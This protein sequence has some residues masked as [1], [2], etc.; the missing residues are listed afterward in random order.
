MNTSNDFDTANSGLRG[1]H[2][3]C[4]CANVTCFVTRQDHESICLSITFASNLKTRLHW[5]RVL[6]YFLQFSVGSSYNN[7]RAV[8]LMR[9]KSDGCEHI[10]TG[11]KMYTH[12]R[13]SIGLTWV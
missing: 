4:T 5:Y 3:R 10:T 1:S 2:Q 6:D 7:E 8:Q 11:E 9:D 13:T 12:A